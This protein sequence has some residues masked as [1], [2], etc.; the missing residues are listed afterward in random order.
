MSNSEPPVQKD[1]QR[2]RSR[3]DI[4]LV[5]DHAQKVP[6]AVLTAIVEE[7]LV[8]CVLGE[9]LTRWTYNSLFNL[10]KGDFV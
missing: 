6:D 3:T 2:G 4:L 9:F 5:F 7:W 1:K 8:P 10:T